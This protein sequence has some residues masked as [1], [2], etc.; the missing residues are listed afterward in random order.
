[1]HLSIKNFANYWR[2]LLY[3]KFNRA[4][5]K[6]AVKVDENRVKQIENEEVKARLHPGVIKS[7]PIEL[8]P[9]INR[10]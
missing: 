1:M 2:L 10:A 9:N 6:I 7:R 8:P 3:K 5:R 4:S